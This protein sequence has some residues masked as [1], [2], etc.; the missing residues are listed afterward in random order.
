MYDSIDHLK[1]QLL[2]GED[3]TFEIKDVCCKGSAV[4]SPHRIQWPMNWEKLSGIKSE[5]LLI[6]DTE[7]RLTIFAAH[8][9]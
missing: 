3:S 8:L 6:D 9:P 2:L 5:Y 7:L 4:S 1:K